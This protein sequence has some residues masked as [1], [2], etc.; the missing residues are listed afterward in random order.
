MNQ[1]DLSRLR[2]ELKEIRNHLDDY[3]D[4]LKDNRPS[5]SKQQLAHHGRQLILL[6][7]YQKEVDKHFNTK[8]KADSDK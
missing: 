6:S 5:F 1:L 4:W 7:K 3:K 2:F 8:W